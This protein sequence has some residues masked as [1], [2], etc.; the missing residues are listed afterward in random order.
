MDLNGNIPRRADREEV[1]R[2]CF[3]EIVVSSTP[4][5]KRKYKVIVRIRLAGALPP[6]RSASL[7]TTSPVSFSR[8]S[9]VSRAPDRRVG[10]HQ[11]R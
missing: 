9:P 4:A 3:L 6:R 8:I 11:R 2:T 7:A 10:R 1:G 5:N